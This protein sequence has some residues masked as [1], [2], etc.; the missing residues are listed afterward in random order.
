M[1]TMHL[2]STAGTTSGSLSDYSAAGASY[3]PPAP[4]PMPMQLQP[5]PFV[6]SQGGIITS[7][8]QVDKLYEHCSKCRECRLRYSALVLGM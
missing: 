2:A 3:R 6:A 5:P 8:I 1:P 7:G 4:Q